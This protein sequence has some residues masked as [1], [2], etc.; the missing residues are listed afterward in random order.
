MAKAKRQKTEDGDVTISNLDHTADVDE[1]G[2]LFDSINEEHI[3][4]AVTTHLL[5]EKADQEY[6]QGDDPL[7]VFH[8]DLFFKKG[9]SLRIPSRESGLESSQS[10]RES[11]PPRRMPSLGAGRKPS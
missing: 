3:N 7:A 5:M 6:A 2:Q 1:I 9:D 10:S 11:S 8:P 4:E